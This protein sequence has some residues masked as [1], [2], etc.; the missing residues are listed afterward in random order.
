MKIKLDT[1]LS[2][3]A[4]GVLDELSRQVYDNL[5]HVERSQPAP[6]T[7]IEP[8]VK[9]RITSLE[10]GR[11][12]QEHALRDAMRALYLHR[13]ASGTLTEDGEIELS[14]RT[15]EMTGGMLHAIEAARLRTVVRHW[16]EYARAVGRSN[17]PL[18]VSE[19]LH[20]VVAIADGLEAAA[21]SIVESGT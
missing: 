5:A 14:K 13:T 11:E 12:D 6:D 18:T 2:T 4:E 9:V 15:I 8:T 21:F 19:L 10:V 3:S 17:K 16:G 1:K 20:E 7:E